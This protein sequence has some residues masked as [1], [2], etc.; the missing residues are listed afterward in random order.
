[1]YAVSTRTVFW[2]SFL[3]KI[4]EILQT[5]SVF[6]S[7]SIPVQELCEGAGL[8]PPLFVPFV[9]KLSRGFFF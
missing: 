1:M 2:E 4:L 7:H 9:R 3:R 5:K 8:A 6:H